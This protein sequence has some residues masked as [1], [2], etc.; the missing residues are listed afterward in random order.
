M[1]L[2]DLFL[3]GVYVF[4][5]ELQPPSGITRDQLQMVKYRIPWSPHAVRLSSW[6]DASH[7][8]EVWMRGCAMPEFRRNI[9][10]WDRE[11]QKIPS[12]NNHTPTHSALNAEHRPPLIDDPDIGCNVVV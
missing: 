11:L 7:A 3:L 6:K 10:D 12:V 2:S 8:L 1:F 9:S 4:L 5:G